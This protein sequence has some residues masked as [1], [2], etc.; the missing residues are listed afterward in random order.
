MNPK[1]ALGFT[2]LEIL[3]A[4]AIFAIIG[5]LALGG[6]NELVKQSET[7]ESTARRTREVQAAVHRLTQDFA[8][9]EP[10]PV[11]DVLGDSRRAALV[12]NTDQTE[13][14]VELTRSSWTNPSGVP[15]STL[16]RVGYRLENGKLRRDYWSAL[17]RTLTAEP[18]SAVLLDDVRSMSLR[19]LD[20]NLEWHEQWPPRRAAG[21]EPMR[22]LP[23]AVEIKLEL[24][25][26]GEIVRLVEIP[27]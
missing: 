23:V 16:Q 11:R 4:V 20:Q 3:V 22:V 18:A 26:W 15:R 7:L 27:G 24:E 14:L 13:R 6:Y 1:R 21:P 25:D 19:F 2:L 17:D 9:L 12:S 8:M 10:R 5:L